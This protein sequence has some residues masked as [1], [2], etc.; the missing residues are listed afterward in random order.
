MLR[1]AC[2]KGS[3]ALIIPA[4]AARLVRLVALKPDVHM[5]AMP[6]PIAEDPAAAFEIHIAEELLECLVGPPHPSRLAAQSA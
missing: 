1:R 5:V 6:G 3:V 2:S 4:V